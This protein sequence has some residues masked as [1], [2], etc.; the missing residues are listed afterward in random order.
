MAEFETCSV[1]F[2]A[3]FATR[4]TFF[5]L[6]SHE[7][8]FIAFST[9]DLAVETFEANGAVFGTRFAFFLVGFVVDQGLV[10]G[11]VL[12]GLMGNKRQKDESYK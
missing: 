10:I 5:F 4:E 1:T 8:V 2:L 11:T 7:K 6:G 9:F 12:E 3:V